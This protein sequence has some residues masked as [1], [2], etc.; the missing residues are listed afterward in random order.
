MYTPPKFQMN[1]F[2]GGFGCTLISQWVVFKL[3]IIYTRTHFRYVY[4]VTLIVAD[5]IRYNIITHIH[6]I[7]CLWIS[8]RTNGMSEIS[9][10][11]KLEQLAPV[12]HFN[13]DAVYK[14]IKKNILSVMASNN[15]P[16]YLNV[17]VYRIQC[18][19]VLSWTTFSFVPNSPRRA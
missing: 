10:T 2:G 12:F 7:P 3:Y 1:W 13:L 8:F 14:K 15:I 5:G 18:T 6:V 4:I 17:V 19:W 9:Y 16:E 11:I